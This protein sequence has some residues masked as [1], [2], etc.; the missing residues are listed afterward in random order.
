M[1]VA[2]AWWL[3]VL[4]WHPL[5]LTFISRFDI[6][7]S[8]SQRFRIV[9][10]QIVSFFCSWCVLTHTRSLALH[11]AHV[12]LYRSW[13]CLDTKNTFEIGCANR[14]PTVSQIKVKNQPHQ[15]EI[16][17][18]SLGI[19]LNSNFVSHVIDGVWQAG[20]EASKKCSIKCH[21]NASYEKWLWIFLTH[22]SP[23]NEKSIRW[24]SC[25]QSC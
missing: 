11:S 18:V 14:K 23:E 22:K 20:R 25:K 4:H 1:D 21:N 6:K 3:K 19:K 17:K 13:V 12:V 24:M 16:F 5:T 7:S 2:S 8:T 9:K 15:N 10:L